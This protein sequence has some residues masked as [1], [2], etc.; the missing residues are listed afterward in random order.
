[1]IYDRIN[2]QGKRSDCNNC[3]DA[4]IDLYGQGDDK[5]W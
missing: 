2:N 5:K 3:M 4:N 1:M